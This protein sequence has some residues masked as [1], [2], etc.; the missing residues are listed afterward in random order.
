[1][2]KFLKKNKKITL[3]IFV[4]LI[5][6]IV[7]F[8]IFLIFRYISKKNPIIEL[9]TNNY[10]IQYDNTWKIV[11]KEDLEINLLHKKSKSELNI[12]INELN[13]EDQYKTVNEIFDSL[14]YNIQAQNPD[15]KL[16][17]N[18]ESKITN[19]N[20]DGY[21]ILFEADDRQATIYMYKQGDK[22]VIFTYEATY[23]YF[24]ILLDSVNNIIYNFNLKE[25]QFDVKTSI[26]LETSEI[27]Y[28]EQS[29]VSNLLENTVNEKI[30]SSNYLVEY[31]IPDNFKSTDYDTRYGYYDFKNAPEGSKVNLSTCILKR[32]LYEYLD[33]E[34][35][36]NIYD[37]YNL[38]S[39]NEAKEELNKYGDK[40]LS[41][42]YKNSYLSNNKITENIQIVYELN[43]NHIFIVKISSEGVGIPEELVKMV[44]VNNFKNIASNINIEKD[45][46]FLIGKLKQYT[47]YT[48]K[49]T[50]EITL[51]L[52]ES[53]QE[54]DKD[55]N[56]YEER[57]YVSDYYEEVQIPK[58]E[59]YY[60]T[61][62][63]NIENELELLD[64]EI[65]KDL[66][67][68][69]DFTQTQD[70]MLNNRKF[71]VYERGYTKLSTNTD[72]SGKKYEYY[73]NEK[74]M[75]YELQNDRYL[76]II[77]NGNGK[78]NKITDELINQLTNFDVNII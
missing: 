1:M 48:C 53:Y 64:K 71:K 76:V 12:K 55:T 36:L 68:Y 63:F 8:S 22:V 26:N 67:T 73:T 74:V 38:N 4:T 40:P 14:L 75:F 57:H 46:G 77:I 41:Y 31:S 66:G 17:Y 16:I 42:I 65:N 59:V 23:D 43:Q 47:D 7:G 45:N 9:N 54:I 25:T 19:K 61:I 34:D 11:K 21:K 6:I 58:Y 60:Q 2:K 5:L 13:D 78:E 52:P 30:A 72:S 3:S 20:M 33:K 62:K 35:T 44:K 29:N 50:E 49:Q 51:K 10:S 39:Y 15:Y 37:D 24:D 28:T 69:K 27:N 32:S 18:E 70:I 56:L